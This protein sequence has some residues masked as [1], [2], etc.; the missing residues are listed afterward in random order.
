M[1][2]VSF[3]RRR[4]GCLAIA[5][6]CSVALLSGCSSWTGAGSPL[7][8]RFS[9]LFASSNSSAAQTAGSG[10]VF[11]D[12]N[13]PVVDIRAGAGTLMVRGKSDSTTATDLR[14]QLSFSRLARQCTSLGATLA[15]K[16]GVQGRVIVGPSGGPGQVEVPLRYAVV[17]EGPEPRTIVTKFKRV[18]V[19]MAAGE[20]NV[21]FTDVQEDLSF[22]LPPQPELDA[23]VVYVGFDEIGDA[24]EK[25][26]AAK[27][28]APKRK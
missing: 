16:V 21:P 26:P 11:E 4:R 12:S 17:R 24:A 7:T 2:V 23:Y 6:L 27:K 13:C 8:G 25:K 3:D 10:P 1:R 5:A 20:T 19:A 9:E 28:A 22:P 14:Y 18:P 15:M